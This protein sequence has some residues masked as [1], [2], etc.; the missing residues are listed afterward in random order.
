MFVDEALVE[1]FAG[2]GGDDGQSG[3]DFRRLRKSW[4]R[5]DFRLRSPDGTVRS[6]PGLRPYPPDAG[7][8]QGRRRYHP[9]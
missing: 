7:S 3:P 4:E 5:A 9:E 1:L 2:D 8:H 6:R